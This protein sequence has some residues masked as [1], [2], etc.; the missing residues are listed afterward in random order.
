MREQVTGLEAVAMECEHVRQAQEERDLDPRVE[1]HV[2]VCHVC[3]AERRVSLAVRATFVLETPADLS[4]RLMALVQPAPQVAR[5]DRALQ[6]AL[7][8]EAPVELTRRLELLVPGAVSVRPA[9]RPWL[10]ALYALTVVAL[11]VLLFFAAQT[12]GVVLQQ[13]GVGV[14]WS[15]VA[16]L[17]SHWLQQ[18][19]A[20]FPQGRYVV[21]TFFALQR[22][23]QW[24]LVGL[25]M[26]AVLEM[27]MPQRTRATA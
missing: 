10:T 6:Q 12:Y 25:V 4:V 27:R 8:V 1:A 26:W 9:R 18:F 7:V 13:L 23:L 15:S 3:A 2:A 17:P 22:A 21:D 20:V 24:V 16:E 14:L 19:Y 5:L 11:G